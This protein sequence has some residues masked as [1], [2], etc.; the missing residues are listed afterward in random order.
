MS[1]CYAKAYPHFPL[2]FFMKKSNKFNHQ[3]RTNPSHLMLYIFEYRIEWN[4]IFF[5]VHHAIAA[6][7]PNITYYSLSV[8][9]GGLILYSLF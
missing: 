2:L 6:E 5:I 3:R 8:Y 1:N 7:I 4:R 9:N